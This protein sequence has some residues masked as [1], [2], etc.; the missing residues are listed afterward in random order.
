LRQGWRFLR[1]VSGDDA[2]ERYREHVARSH[3]DEMPLSRAEHFRLRQ[4]QKWNRVSRCC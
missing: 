2:Y 1:Q 4:E 3:P